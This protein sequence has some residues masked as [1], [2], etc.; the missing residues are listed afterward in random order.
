M[1]IDIGSH[2]SDLLL[3]VFPGDWELLE[4]RDNARGGIETDC[5]LRLKLT[6]NDQPV[7]G[8]ASN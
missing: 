2:V 1:L 4:Y 8:S 3:Y 6:H 7:E 5:E